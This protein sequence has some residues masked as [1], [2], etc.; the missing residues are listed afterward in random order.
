[1]S[2]SPGSGL[3]GL[4]AYFFRTT[5]ADNLLIV[6]IAVSQFVIFKIFYP[7]PDFFSDSYSYL[8]AASARLDANI[9]PIGYSWFLYLFHKI[10]HS[11]TAL[12]L[13]QYLFIE[14]SALY[15]YRTILFLFSVRPYVRIILMAF[16][17]LNPL[18]LYL[19]NFISSDGLFA[20]MSLLWLTELI[21]LIYCPNIFHLVAISVTCLVAFTFRYNAM[22][23]P[24]IGTLPYLIMKKKWWYK[25]VGVVLGPSL[26][27][28]FILFSSNAAK[29]MS[30]TAQ[31]PPI[32][33]GWQWANNALYMREYISEDSTRFPNSQMGE[34]DRLA[35]QFYR[36]IP[37]ENRNLPSYVGN[38][39]IIEWN[40]PLKIYMLK[41]FPDSTP[42]GVF[43]WAKSAPLF[44]EYGM[45]LIKRHPIPYIKH[46]L[47]V[48]A[49]NYFLPPL[50]KLEKYNLGKKRIS[51]IAAKW[52]SY[53]SQDV[54]APPN[55][56][57]RFLL[58]G[59]PMLFLLL[60]IF[61]WLNI[62]MFVRKK[63][64]QKSDKKLACVV[65]IISVLSILNACFSIF[66]NIVVFRYQI[67]P[68]TT[69]LFV[70][71]LMIPYSWRNEP[72]M[73]AAPQI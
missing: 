15:F 48:N 43:A 24:L 32:L 44:K 38:Y 34:L 11:A 45:Y 3:Y 73:K 55:F 13:F 17:F 54:H 12:N 35:R 59:F 61:F 70:S 52:F 64:F 14:L 9:W 28:P 1:M 71:L 66:A 25:F 69:L 47:S 27:I 5:G 68:M 22:Y 19:A 42:F 33:G 65:G 63:G 36:R 53:S 10:T 60:N 30:G 58:S 49:I 40:A 8:Y 20:A 23:Y 46:Y 4:S 29:K 67:F 50:E 26:I 18:N 39:F 2:V 72:P 51:P 7:F 57:Q 56:I 6:F 21:W 62:S 37:P 16:F 41:N 31:F